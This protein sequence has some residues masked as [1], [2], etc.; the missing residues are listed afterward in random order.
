MLAPAGVTP[1][2]V[3][4]TIRAVMRQPAFDRAMGDTLWSRL[5]EWLASLFGAFRRATG[6]SPLLHWLSIAIV[7]LLVAAVAGRIAY[8][9]WVHR[10][11]RAAVAR[12]ARA[13][14]RAGGDPWLA[15]Q[16]LAAA[17]DY[18][19][20]AHALYAA[21]LESVA[22]RERLTLHP[23]RTVGDYV[24]DLRARSST[25]FGRFREFARSYETVVY[26]VGSCDRERY[27]RLH[28][29]ATATVGGDA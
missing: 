24:R 17:G 27:E 4:D 21:L 9:A 20:A 23:S 15:A 13:R 19:G 2:A 26:G 10:G 25:L 7:A 6:D 1:E 16:A 22:R 29:L 14:G 18:T 28:A 11:V 8:L 12:G 5:I 3:R